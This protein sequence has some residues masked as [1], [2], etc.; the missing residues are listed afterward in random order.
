VSQSEKSKVASFAKKMMKPLRSG[1][2]GS[3]GEMND[4]EAILAAL[5]S[6]GDNPV[7]AWV[8]QKSAM[9]NPGQT[10]SDDYLKILSL[11]SE[12]RQAA[13]TFNPQD[14]AKKIVPEVEAV[15]ELFNQARSERFG[16]LQQAA[17][18]S[19]D[20]KTVPGVVNEIKSSIKDASKLK[21]I[22][23]S[24]KN[25]LDDV[26]NMI[27]N[28]E[29]TRVH[30]LVPGH[31]S[32]ATQ[33][34]QFN[35][36]QKARSMLD[37]KI[38]WAQGQG[39]SEAEIILKSTRDKIDE[40]LKTSPEKIEGDALWQKSK[41]LEDRFFET[42]KFGRKGSRD[43]DAEKIKTLLGDNPTAR[44][45]S[46][47]LQDMKEFANQPGLNPEFK[48]RMLAAIK[49][50]EDSIGIAD[51]QRALSSF[52]YQQGPSSPAIER[53]QSTVGKQSLIGDA[54]NAPAG[55]LNSADEF[56]KLVKQ[57]TGVAYEQLDT[58]QK[59]KAVRAWTWMKSNPGA[60][61]EQTERAWRKFFGN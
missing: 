50:I 43:V 42:T 22:P 3:V 29:G 9:L 33:A 7:K 1:E 27:V 14:A 48:E 53:L 6:D 26:D 20:P 5:L 4:E 61:M 41:E 54:V 21:S 51:Q 58:A 46:K 56:A 40:A 36:L 24:V 59:A 12:S 34:E 31:F 38:T 60:S 57:R 25:L 39:D 16:A 8:A 28:G 10:S 15:E 11:P 49:N 13:R 19:F 35:R 37:K 17:Q 32:Q 23:G 2:A 52:R 30:K 18:E 45:N 55:F 44:R 47:T